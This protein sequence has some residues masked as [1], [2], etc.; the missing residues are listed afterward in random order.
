MDSARGYQD[1]PQGNILVDQAVGGSASAM[2]GFGETMI[3]LSL[4]NGGI[5]HASSRLDQQ[6]SPNNRG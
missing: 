6:A 5:K 2:K 4:R 3:T 1:K